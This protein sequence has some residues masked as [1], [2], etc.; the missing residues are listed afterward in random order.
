MV[1]EAVDKILKNR[2][3]KQLAAEAASVAHCLSSR[4]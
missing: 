1:S 2:T 3:G 4:Q